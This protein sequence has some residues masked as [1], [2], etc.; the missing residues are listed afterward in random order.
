MVSVELT[1]RAMADLRE[2]H[3][4]SIQTFGTKVAERYLDDVEAALSI[5]Q[6]QPDILLSKPGI[7]HFFQFYPV[8]NHHLVCTRLSDTLI[9]LTIKH[10]QM[11]LPE[12]LLE[13]EH[14]LQ[15]E[16][17]LLYRKLSAQ[18]RGT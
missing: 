1:H 3:D 11:D 5:L 6:E 16:A 17:E 8:R 15:Q 14:T 10:C 2:I 9:I 7:S 12:R 13:I 4:Y 18:T